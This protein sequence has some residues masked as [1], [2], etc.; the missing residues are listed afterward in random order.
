MG[1]SLCDLLT[2]VSIVG[3]H[4]PGDLQV[5]FKVSSLPGQKNETNSV[6]QSSPFL[7]APNDGVNPLMRTQISPKYLQRLSPFKWA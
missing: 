7:P 6:V 1:V 5:G 4:N 3:L 2:P